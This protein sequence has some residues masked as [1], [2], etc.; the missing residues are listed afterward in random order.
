MHKLTPEELDAIEARCEAAT[1]G[2]WRAE[3]EKA[4]IGWGAQLID[5]H[6]VPM[7]N[8]GLWISSD[9][10]KAHR[11]HAFIAASRQDIPRLVAALRAAYEEIEGWKIEYAGADAEAA[12]LKRRLERLKKGESC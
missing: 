12:S 10:P 5:G 9:K 8:L 4:G 3:V 1:P 2:P 6:G 11:D 7:L